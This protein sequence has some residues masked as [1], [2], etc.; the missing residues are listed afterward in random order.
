MT[1]SYLPASHVRVGDKVVD[2]YGVVHTVGQ[3]AT[4]SHTVALRVAGRGP[5]YFLLDQPVKVVA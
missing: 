4:S 3:I 2:E 1:S 5:L